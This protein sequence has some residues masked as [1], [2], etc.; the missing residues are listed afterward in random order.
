MVAQRVIEPATLTIAV[1]SILRH[2]VS[3]HRHADSGRLEMRCKPGPD[4]RH[5]LGTRDRCLKD[6]VQLNIETPE[7]I[8]SYR[9]W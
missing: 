1:D 6:R 2:T 8:V 5:L 3:E 9:Q 7:K 4:F